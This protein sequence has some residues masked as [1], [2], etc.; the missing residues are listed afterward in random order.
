[1]LTNNMN[2]M[3]ALG[4]RLVGRSVKLIKDWVGTGNKYHMHTSHA[5]DTDQQMIKEAEAKDT[6]IR[7]RPLLIGKQGKC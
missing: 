4:N 2:M 5:H 3:A 1:M 7:A 6:H